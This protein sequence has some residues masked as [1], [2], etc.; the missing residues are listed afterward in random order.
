MSG[1][2]RVLSTTQVFISKDNSY[3]TINEV[4]SYG[5]VE[6]FAQSLI[7]SERK[8]VG[9]APADGKDYDIESVSISNNHAHLVFREK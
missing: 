7:D 3:R 2:S 5:F 1:D 4:E 8:P 9:N 6:S